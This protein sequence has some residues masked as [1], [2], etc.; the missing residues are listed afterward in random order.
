MFLLLTCSKQCVSP[1]SPTFRM[2]DRSCLG[3]RIW[4]SSTRYLCTMSQHQSAK[5]DVVGEFLHYTNEPF[6][7]TLRGSSKKKGA[8][9][10]IRR[11]TARS[12]VQ[13]KRNQQ[14]VTQI[15][16]RYHGATD[17]VKNWAVGEETA[18]KLRTLLVGEDA[19][20]V[21]P[22]SEWGLDSK[23]QRRIVRGATLQTQQLQIVLDLSKESSPIMR[24]EKLS[25]NNTGSLHLSHDRVK[26]RRLDPTDP[27]WHALGLTTA[28]STKFP[29]KLKPGMHSKFRQCEKFVEIV[30]QLI[31]SGT[32]GRPISIV[33]MGCGRG[34]LTFALHSFLAQQYP[35]V[36][37]TGIDVR[38]KL[39]NEINS[40]AERLSLPGLSFQTGTIAS[41]LQ[42]RQEASNITSNDFNI[43]IALHACDTATDDAIWSG[44]QSGA[45]LIVVAPC[46]HKELRSQLDRSSSSNHPYSDVLRHGI[47]RERMAETVTDSLRALLL[48]SAGYNHVRVFEFI[49]GEHTAKNVMITALKRGGAAS[50]QKSKDAVT[51]RIRA[52]SEFHAIRHQKLAKWM[53]I[54][55][56]SSDETISG[57]Y[58]PTGMPP[59]ER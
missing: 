3:S 23:Q 34:Y 8:R 36:Q 25:S 5:H 1:F 26:S 50:K 35:T 45:D 47:Y 58:F 42:N 52:L 24:E 15:T 57:R 40:I 30:S 4:Q 48:E 14:N 41:F 32:Q 16:F 38:P 43:L 18:V 20:S 28:P 37:S 7:L 9:G 17:V 13:L 2:D 46:C 51:S 49:G 44:I 19:T 22:A 21:I 54:S 39:V 33:D 27:L 11:I 56:T 29:S 53:G 59:L 55:L 6:T 12:P 31:P 10:S